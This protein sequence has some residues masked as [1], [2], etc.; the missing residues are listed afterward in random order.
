MRESDIGAAALAAYLLSS[1]ALGFA[2]AR[3]E[4]SAAEAR[5]VISRARFLAGRTGWPRHQLAVAD[6]AAELLRQ[7]ERFVAVAAR[8]VGGDVAR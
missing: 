5:R 6:R 7:T 1:A 4:L 2:V 3:R 8:S